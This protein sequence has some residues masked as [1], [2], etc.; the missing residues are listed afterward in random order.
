MALRRRILPSWMTTGPANGKA[1]TD[2]AVKA[3][4]EES[5]GEERTVYCMNEAELV[6]AALAILTESQEQE[7][8]PE[9]PSPAGS[10]SPQLPSA[11]PESPRSPES[12]GDANLDTGLVPWGLVGSQEEEEKKE[13]EE[14]DD[15]KYVREIFFS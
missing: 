15:M 7:R 3:P 12:S 2:P 1:N 13:E 5:V 11:Q 8:P 6:D 10:D 14:D 9:P 4:A